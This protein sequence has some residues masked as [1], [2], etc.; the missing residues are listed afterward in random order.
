M[1]SATLIAKVIRNRIKK[2]LY[3]TCSAGVASNKFL[4]KVASEW[5]KPDG[6]FVIIPAASEEFIKQLPVTK[7]FGVGKV[8]AKKLH[9]MQIKTCLDLQAIPLSKLIEQFGK[10]GL[11]FYHLCRG[12]DDRLVEPEQTRKSLSVEET[13]PKDVATLEECLNLLPHIIKK[14][15][16]NLAKVSDLN[17]AKQF[18]KIKFYDF[19]RTAVEKRVSS[20]DEKLFVVLLEEGFNRYNKPVR[21]LGVGVRFDIS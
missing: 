4:A 7:I 16:R 10:M 18:V 6:L 19:K 12:V 1:V 20:F 13:F 8:T 11:R 15:K 2:E 17:V 9:D 21:L 14:L 5:N 3:L